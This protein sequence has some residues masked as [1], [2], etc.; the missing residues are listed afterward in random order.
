MGSEFA[1][2]YLHP[3]WQ[4]AKKY[5][6][7]HKMGVSNLSERI[8]LLRLQIH[9]IQKSTKNTRAKWG[10]NFLESVHHFY[11]FTYTKGDYIIFTSNTLENA[12]T[13]SHLLASRHIIPQIH[14]ANHIYGRM[15]RNDFNWSQQSCVC[16]TVHDLC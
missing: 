15:L 12:A 2:D 4:S 13:P 10:I 7:C 1:I 6:I 16:K 11:I 3:V 9:N 14:V 5:Q 8:S